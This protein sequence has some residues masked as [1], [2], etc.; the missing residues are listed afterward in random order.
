MGLQSV[1]ELDI[2]QTEGGHQDES[3]KL[4]QTM[5]EGEVH[6]DTMTWTIIVQIT[7]QVIS[8]PKKNPPLISGDLLIAKYKDDILKDRN[9]NIDET[10][11]D[12]LGHHPLH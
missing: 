12:S 8:P 3:N 10:S 2:D 7:Y 1:L 6:H 9:E 4:S 11:F 5:R